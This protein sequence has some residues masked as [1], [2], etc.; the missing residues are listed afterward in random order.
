MISRNIVLLVSIFVLLVEGDLDSND[1]GI[2]A[3]PTDKDSTSDEAPTEQARRFNL[4]QNS[5]GW[6]GESM[7]VVSPDYPDE[8][9]YYGKGPSD[10]SSSS[11]ETSDTPV[12]NQVTAPEPVVAAA[13][14]VEEEDDESTDSDEGGKKKFSSRSSK[15]QNPAHIAQSPVHVAHIPA[16]PPLPIVPQPKAL[17][18]SR[19]SKRR[20]RT[21]R[22]QI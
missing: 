10:T 22:R 7:N 9:Q 17:V 18:R 6:I 16:P 1:A 4:Q 19:V 12:P 3:M 14:S 20:S 5:N 11:S 21:N 13:N 2:Q 15:A 8:S